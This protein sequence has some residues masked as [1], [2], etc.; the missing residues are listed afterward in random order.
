[1]NGQTY[2]LSANIKSLSGNRIKIPSWINLA[3]GYGANGLLTGN[4]GNV[5]HDKNNV[6]HDFSIVKRYR[7]FYIS[8]DIDLTRIKTK[9]KGLKFFFK[10]A[11]CVKFPMPAVEYN[12]V[13][14]V[15]WHWLKF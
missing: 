6:E 5:W 12:K 8:P 15:K 2:W 1:Y 13:Q 3:A 7:Q 9:H 4:P 10:I 14:G 11:N